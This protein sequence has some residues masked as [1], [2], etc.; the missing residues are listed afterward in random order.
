[1]HSLADSTVDASIQVGP[2][3]GLLLGFMD[4]RAARDVGWLVRVIIC[5]GFVSNTTKYEYLL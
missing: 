3:V 5:I 4:L 1:M 2:V